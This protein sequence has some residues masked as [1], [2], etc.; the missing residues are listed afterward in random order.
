[1]KYHAGEGIPSP[2]NESFRAG[3]LIDIRDIGYYFSSD[4]EAPDM[5]PAV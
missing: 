4:L 1:L 5:Y 3:V 2:E